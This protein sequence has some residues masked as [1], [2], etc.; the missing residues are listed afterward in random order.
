M[1]SHI[2]KQVDINILNNYNIQSLTLTP[3]NIWYIRYESL[4]WSKSIW[5]TWTK[6]ASINSVTRYLESD[7]YRIYKVYWKNKC[8]IQIIFL[9]NKPCACVA[10]TIPNSPKLSQVFST[11]FGKLKKSENDSDATEW[12]CRQVKKRRLSINQSNNFL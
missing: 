1:K 3:H 9:G 4:S 12:Q 5:I 8:K 10:T 7:K 11:S 2:S 6:L